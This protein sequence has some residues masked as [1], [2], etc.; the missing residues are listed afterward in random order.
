[1][2][3]SNEVKVK[4]EPIFD[5][6]STSDTRKAT[7]NTNQQSIKHERQF[8][9]ISD[10]K[11]TR[12]YILSDHQP[13]KRKR[14]SMK[15]KEEPKDIEMQASKSQIE[16]MSEEVE[17]KTD[18]EEKF[19]ATEEFA[20]KISIAFLNEETITTAKIITNQQTTSN[21]EPNNLRN[22]KLK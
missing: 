3:A 16:S 6:Q 17:I 19:S 21:N 5:S 7:T 2:E 10:S 20:N 12:E 11:R 4:N 9:L 8:I 22:R 14:Q 15:V 18:E 1:M 13:N